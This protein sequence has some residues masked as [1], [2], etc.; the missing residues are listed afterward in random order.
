MD[1]VFLITLVR[2]EPCEAVRDGIP[3]IPLPPGT[4]LI[5]FGGEQSADKWRIFYTI[6]FQSYLNV[7]WKPNKIKLD[8]RII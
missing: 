7:Q 3:N 2:S 4:G 5:R 1:A 8:A 6:L